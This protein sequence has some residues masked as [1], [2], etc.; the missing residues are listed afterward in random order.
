MFAYKYIL[1]FCKYAISSHIEYLHSCFI[2]LFSSHFFLAAV[3]VVAWNNVF[4]YYITVILSAKHHIYLLFASS[5]FK[6][7]IRFTI[8]LL[9][10]I[11]TKQTFKYIFELYILTHILHTQTLVI[12]IL[13]SHYTFKRNIERKW[14]GEKKRK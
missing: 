1:S 9:K 3:V 12:H 8:F 6:V 10:S 5:S 7:H 4:Y 14:L 11:W 2:P 13:D